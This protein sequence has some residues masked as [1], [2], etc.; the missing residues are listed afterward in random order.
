M[1]ELYV[2]TISRDMMG[3]L[4]KVMSADELNDYVLVGGTAL[5]LQMGHRKSVD[6]DLFTNKDYEPVVLKTVIP[7]L[8]PK[9]YL[10]YERNNGIGYSIKEVKVEFVQWKDGQDFSFGQFGTWRLLRKSGIASMKLNA[11]QGRQEKKDFADLFFLL[12]EKPLKVIISDYRKNYPYL[13][14]RPILEKLVADIDQ[15]PQPDPI[16]IKQLPWPSVKKEIHQAVKEYYQELAQERVSS[17]EQAKEKAKQYK[18][19]RKD[20]KGT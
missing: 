1:E 10:M 9:A 3:I 7:K 12:K 13:Q 6:I 17:I 16:F 19:E 5:S 14:I 18:K 4:D 15:L 20:E 8:F 11:I 2:N